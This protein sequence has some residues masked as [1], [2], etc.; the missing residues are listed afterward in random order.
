[1]QTENKRLTN[2]PPRCSY[3]DDADKNNNRTANASKMFH[4][5]KSSFVLALAR[6]VAVFP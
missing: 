2:G 6:W 3:N 5:L 1:M 4:A